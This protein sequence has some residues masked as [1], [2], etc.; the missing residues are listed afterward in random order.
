ML[1]Q[2][3]KNSSAGKQRPQDEW[4]PIKKYNPLEMPLQRPNNSANP[5]SPFEMPQKINF[6]QVN[7]NQVLSVKID[8][9]IKD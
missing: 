9:N 6:N 3:N 2:T 7:D 4:I 8:T 1:P 5:F